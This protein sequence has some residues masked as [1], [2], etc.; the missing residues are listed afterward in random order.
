M[1]AAPVGY[2]TAHKSFE[3]AIGGDHRAAPTLVTSHGL[4]GALAN[5]G[6]ESGRKIDG[7]RGK[8]H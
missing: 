7:K 5:K 2:G 6:Q 8:Y 1:G 3:Q 4:S